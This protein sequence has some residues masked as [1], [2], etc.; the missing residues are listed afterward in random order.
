[1]VYTL[2]DMGN[3]CQESVSICQL[4]RLQWNAGSAFVLG[5]LVLGLHVL[6]YLQL[7]LHHY[8]NVLMKVH[9]NVLTEFNSIYFNVVCSFFSAKQHCMN[10]KLMGNKSWYGIKTLVLNNGA[11]CS[12]YMPYISPVHRHWQYQRCCRLDCSVNEAQYSPANQKR[13]YLYI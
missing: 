11:H 10:E 2:L 3:Y 5:L 6:L 1:M 13:Q 8:L 9:N 4:T 7:M 12:I